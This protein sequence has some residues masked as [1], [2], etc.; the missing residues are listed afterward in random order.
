M[1]ETDVPIFENGA[2]NPIGYLGCGTKLC[3]LLESGALTITPAFHN[4]K[5]VEVSII[6]PS[7]VKVKTTFPN[8]YQVSE[9]ELQWLRD[10][11]ERYVTR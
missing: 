6:R 11:V 5:L 10:L 4:G 1:S 2:T 8:T 7:K 3:E 9:P